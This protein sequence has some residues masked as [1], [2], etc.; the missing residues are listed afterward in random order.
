MKPH[1][2][3]LLVP[4]PADSEPP[5]TENELSSTPMKVMFDL[6]EHSIPA[7]SA[8]VE[9]IQFVPVPTSVTELPQIVTADVVITSIST[10]IRVMF[11]FSIFTKLSVEFPVTK[12]VDM[13]V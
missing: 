9:I 8:A 11:V 12:I 4:I 2:P 5:F 13:K 10:K 1:I 6:D 3:F 7:S